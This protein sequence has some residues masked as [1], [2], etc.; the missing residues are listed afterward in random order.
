MKIN[1]RKFKNK[2]KTLVKRVEI[3]L[4]LQC[5]SQRQI[6]N[7]LP[8][9]KLVNKKQKQQTTNIQHTKKTV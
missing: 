2:I 3:I 6:S 8:D 9:S 5:F 4:A 1:E 7:I